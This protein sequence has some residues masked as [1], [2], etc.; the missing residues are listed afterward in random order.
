M[1]ELNIVQLRKERLPGELAA[2]AYSII[3]DRKTQQDF[4]GTFAGPDRVLAVLCDGMGGLMGGER[5]SREAAGMLLKDYETKQP[6]KNFADFLCREAVRM[7]ARV[8]GLKSRDG[9]R[10]D[11][12]TTVVAAVV[13]KDGMAEWMSV[14][15]SRIYLLR[16]DRFKQLTRDQNYRCFLE[17][18][19]RRGEITQEY[20][21][22]ETKGRMAEALTSYLGIGNIKRIGKS[23]QE[24][25]LKPGDQLLLCSDGLYKSLSS[26]QIKAMLIDNQIDV[27][28]SVRRLVDMA[29]AKASKKQDNTTVIL[30]QYHGKKTEE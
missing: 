17:D 26:D 23:R 16:G 21:D 20:Y 14:G 18:S 27:R 10:L 22:Q 30:I 12:G 24:I 2:E 15:D 29:L 9:R 13:S 1:N 3:G 5:A 8:H 25:L 6:S 7:D 11:A 28:V 4:A 19:L